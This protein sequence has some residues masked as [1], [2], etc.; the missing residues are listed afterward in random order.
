LLDNKTH[1]LMMRL[2]EE[3]RSLL[4][5][6]IN[7]VNQSISNEECR[8][9]LKKLEN[10]KADY[11]KDLE[12]LLGKTSNLNLEINPPK[13]LR[14]MLTNQECPEKGIEELSKCYNI[15]MK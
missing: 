8:N 4:R 7:Y 6:K 5:K 1:N 12:A 9:F 11:I 14:A 2:I 10:E 3:K 13:N 15:Q